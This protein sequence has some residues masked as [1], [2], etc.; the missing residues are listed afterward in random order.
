MIKDC[1]VLAGPMWRYLVLPCLFAISLMAE[2]SEWTVETNGL[3]VKEPSTLRGDFDAAIGDVNFS[4]PVTSAIRRQYT[5]SVVV[6][7]QCKA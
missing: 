4:L 5:E 3:R 6:E 1:L 2:A 7:V